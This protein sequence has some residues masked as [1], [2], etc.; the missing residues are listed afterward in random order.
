MRKS[1]KSRKLK[2]VEDK[3]DKKER[4]RERGNERETNKR[5]D[6]LT[7]KALEIL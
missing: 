5:K 6:G 4:W 7:I 1:K 2:E 3:H